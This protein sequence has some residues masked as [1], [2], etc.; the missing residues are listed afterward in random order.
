[1]LTGCGTL[2]RNDLSRLSIYKDFDYLLTVGLTAAEIEQVKRETGAKVGT[3]FMHFDGPPIKTPPIPAK[4]AKVVATGQPFVAYAGPHY[5]VFDAPAVDWI[6]KD[7]KERVH[8]SNFIFLDNFH[9]LRTN[10]KTN[11]SLVADVDADG[12]G[13]IDGMGSTFAMHQKSALAIVQALDAA[14][15]KDVEIIPNTGGRIRDYPEFCKAVNGCCLEDRHIRT[16]PDGTRVCEIAFTPA[17][18]GGAGRSAVGQRHSMAFLTS[19]ETY[20]QA[21]A[22]TVLPG[23]VVRMKARFLH[24]EVAGI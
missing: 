19:H 10:W 23:N 15:P 20:K 14:L 2:K 21:L 5:N 22:M 11:N 24:L 4:Y 1:M 13:D 7:V 8:S 17:D 3:Y 16:L 18:F 12:D 6:V 9:P